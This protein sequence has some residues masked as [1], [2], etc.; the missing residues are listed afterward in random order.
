MANDTARLEE[1]EVGAH[2]E[3][4]TY[5]VLKHLRWYYADNMMN[6][7]VHSEPCDNPK[8]HIEFM[9]KHDL[10]RQEMPRWLCESG[11]AVH[12]RL[13][14][15]LDAKS[16]SEF[17]VGKDVVWAHVESQKENPREPEVL[18]AFANVWAVP[19]LFVPIPD[20]VLFE[21]QPG[22]FDD[23]YSDL[24]FASPGDVVERVG[25]SVATWSL[26]AA[27]WGWPFENDSTPLLLVHHIQDPAIKV[28][29]SQEIARRGFN[30]P[31]MQCQ[32]SLQPGL[33]ITVVSQSFDMLDGYCQGRSNTLRLKPRPVRVLHT[34]VDLPVPAAHA[35]D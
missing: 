19:G 31:W 7:S 9:N 11:K 10:W 28:F 4:D 34:K 33:R 23:D 27:T 20:M 22:R 8:L 12:E 14:P 15:V 18:Q 5:D 1:F 6:L 17:R 21:G 3:R 26:N 35:E 30:S 24:L 2:V 29:A 16:L 25:P 13:I 32:V